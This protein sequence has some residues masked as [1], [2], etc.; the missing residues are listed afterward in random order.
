MFPYPSGEG[1]HMGHM[2]NY[3]IGDV[4]ARYKRMQGFNVL[5]PMGYDSFGL[6][7]ENAAI[8]RN[9]NPKEWTLNN[10]RLMESQ[11]KRLGFSYDW[12]RKIITCLPDYYRWNQWLFLQLYKKGLAYKKKAVVNFCPSCKTVLANE[13]VVD[14]K[15]WRCGSNVK[16]KVLEQWFF[17][18]T[19]Y[20]E[21]LLDDL[22]K[23]DWPEK[24]KVMQRNW[25]GK[26][27]GI[28]INFKVKDS[29][30]TLKVFTTRPDTLFGVTFLAFAP[31]H[32]LLLELVKGTE[33]EEKVKKF[34]E[35]VRKKK[36]EEPEAIEK[37]K[38][39][40]FI[41][42]YAINPANNEE[43]P[44]YV[45]NFVLLEY[46]TGIVM[47]VPAHDQR[48]FEFAKKKG[49][50]IKIVIR[51]K[52]KELDEKTMNEAY[53]DEG[54]L[55][56]S[57]QFDGLSSEEAR[58]KICEWLEKEGVGK[59]TV[60]YKL[61]DWLI[62]RQRYWGTPIPVVYCEKCGI[63]PVPEEQL[64]VMLPEPSQVKFGEGNPLETCK[65]FV[66]TTCPR[67]KGKAKR[68]TD[69][70][71]TFVDS[72]WYFL[73][74]CDP[75]NQKEIFDKN[76]V[77]YWMPVDFY[78]GGIEHATG[79][80]IYSRFITK[81]LRDL[82]LIKFDEPFKKLLCQGMVTLGG[83]AMSKSRGNVVDPL[84]IADKYGADTARLFILFAASPEKQLEWSEKG[85]EGMF[86]FVKRIFSLKDKK[87]KETSRVLRH[88]T[89]KT[90]RE[91][92]KHIE[93][94]KFNLAIIELMKFEAYL[95]KEISKEAFETFLKLLAP[96]APH[97]AEE[98]WHQLG[99]KTFISLEKWPSVDESAIDE[100]IE[101]ELEMQ[102][103]LKQ[104]LRNIVKMIKKKK[105]EKIKKIY[106]YVVPK[107]LSVF[108]PLSE[109]IKKEF[110]SDVFIEPT[111]KVSYDPENKAK[112]AKPGKPAIYIE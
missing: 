78:V 4:I 90:V 37:E 42:K 20:A 102:E 24:V 2:R 86:R 36:V 68:E 39:G 100:N 64:P 7:A 16:I 40:I 81:V 43:I 32:P 52:D 98:L 103:K 17:K 46:G 94:F 67:C 93:N 96:F 18:I 71:D 28:L 110:N 41:G 15:C 75:K 62:S 21:E 45:A 23:V 60:E 3:A 83:V 79:H 33:Y 57:S 61:K 22:E 34:I 49:L 54:I 109:E 51:P 1:L 11:Q 104:D 87:F 29:N 6:P 97:I 74:Y 50:P 10:I 105:K 77:A 72:S 35:E 76:K 19:E 47:G 25:I 27:E 38:E 66:E 55:I 108:S 53:V 70:M 85:I 8:A 106:I 91:V 99:N 101:K 58:E 73:R 63:V 95:E 56:N 9:A 82:G 44:I 92:T 14:G 59:R 89:N 65:E 12:K 26:S 48:D 88:L 84:A 31:E 112:R 13:Q 80:L 107:E 30:T 111:D 5:Y 69:T